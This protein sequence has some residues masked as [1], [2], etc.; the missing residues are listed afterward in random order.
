MAATLCDWCRGASG[1]NASSSSKI[2]GS[3]ITGSVNLMPPCTM[4]CP[5][6]TIRCSPSIPLRPQ[7]K[8]NSIASL[9]PRAVVAFH[10]CSRTT[11]PA[12]SRTKNRGWVISSSNCPR[13][14]RSGGSPSRKTENLRLEEPAFRVSSA[15]GMNSTRRERGPSEIL[16]VL[17]GSPHFHSLTCWSYHQSLWCLAYQAGNGFLGNGSLQQL[18][19]PLRP[20]GL[21]EDIHPLAKTARDLAHSCVSRILF[22]LPTDQRIPEASPA[23]G[24]ADETRDCSCG[25]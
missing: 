3:I 13:K 14:I 24:E 10:S 20:A 5:T 4:R 1:T 2:W 23:H 22:V 9:S 12:A 8:R 7:S 18:R 21:L 19:R 16:D 6:A 11:S 17:N 25:R 15:S